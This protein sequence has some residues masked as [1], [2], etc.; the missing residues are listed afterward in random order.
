MKKALIRD[1]DFERV[2]AAVSKFARLDTRKED[3]RTELKEIFEIVP[4]PKVVGKI[5][6]QK[7]KQQI[8][9]DLGGSFPSMYD[10]PW[11]DP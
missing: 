6:S 9:H 5:G 11:R 1:I 8:N 3:I 2:V 10:V 4:T 7:P